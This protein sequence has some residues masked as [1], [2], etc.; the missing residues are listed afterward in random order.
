MVSNP[1]ILLGLDPDKVYDYYIQDSCAVGY[2]GEWQGPCSFSTMFTDI[3]VSLH[4]ISYGLVSWGDYDN[5]NDLDIFILGEN[6][7]IYRND[8]NDLFTFVDLNIPELLYGSAAICDYDNDGDLDFVNSG[9]DEI[10]GIAYSKIYRNDGSDVFTDINADLSGVYLSSVTWG[11]YDNDGDQDLLITGFD[12]DD[13]ETSQFYINE[14]NDK[15]SASDTYIKGSEAGTVIFGDFDNDDYIDLLR[16]GFDNSGNK[17]SIIYRN[18]GDKTF[19][20]INAGLAPFTYSAAVW[21]DFDSD[22]DLDLVITG[23]SGLSQKR[24]IFYRNDGPGDS[25]FTEVN[26]GLHNVGIGGLSSGDFNNDGHLDILLTGYDEFN[27]VTKV[28]L[29]NGSGSFTDSYVTIEGYYNGTTSSGDYDNDGDLDLLISG[30]D[31]PTKIYKNNSLTANT[32]PSIPFNLSYNKKVHGATLSWNSATDSETNSNALSYNL[33]IGT[34]PDTFDIVSPI[35]DTINGYRRIQAMGNAFLDTN[36]VINNIDTGIYYWS[37]QTIDNGF[38]GSEFSDP[39]TFYIQGM[40]TDIKNG[41]DSISSM[42]WGDYDNDNDLDILVAGSGTYYRRYVSKIYANNGND[43]FSEIIFCTDSIDGIVKWG[44][45]DNDGDLDIF[46]SGDKYIDEDGGYDAPLTKIY[47]NDGND[48]FIDINAGLT[49]IHFTSMS[50]G[51]FDNDGDLDIIMSGASG[52][53]PDYNPVSKIYI[54]EGN[55]IFTGIDPGLVSIFLGSIAIGDYNNDSDIDILITGQDSLENRIS[56]IYRN[57]GDL[58]FTDIDAGI[59]GVYR[60]SVAWGDYDKDGDLDIVI[61]GHDVNNNYVT[62][63]YRND[64]GDIFTDINAN[65]LGISGGSANWGDYD[66]DGDLDILV[67]G[68]NRSAVTKIYLNNCD[69]TFT[70]LDIDLESI[71]LYTSYWGDYDNDGDLDFFGPRYFFDGLFRNN[72]NEPNDA[73]YKPPNLRCDFQ[74]SNTVLSWDKASDNQGGENGLSYNIRVGTTPGAYDIIAPM[75]DLNNGY[76]MI[77]EMGNANGNTFF[78]LKD[79]PVGIYYWSV[80]AI[81]QSFAGGEWADEQVITV[82]VLRADFISDTVCLSFPTGFT[83]LSFTSGSPIL[84]WNWDFGDGITSTEQNPTHI[85]ESSG[86]HQV[87]LLVQSAEYSDSIIQEVL[88]KPKPSTDFITDIAC[89]RSST[90]FT[91]NTSLNGTTVTGWYWDFGDGESSTLQDPSSHGYLNSGNYNVKLA[92]YADNGCAD[93]I[94]NIVTVAKYPVAA[95]TASS[96]FEFCSGDSV[97]LSVDYNDNYLYTWKIGAAN[98]TGGDSSKFSA[99]LTGAYSVEVVNSIGNCTTLSGDANIIALDAPSSPYISADGPLSFCDGDSVKL[100]ITENSDYT[101]QW[102]LNGGAVGS[103]S[104]EYIAKNQGAFTVDITNSS[105]C[106]ETSS[107]SIDVVV[108]ESPVTGTVNLSGATEFCEGGSLVMSVEQ[109]DSYTYQWRDEYGII[110]GEITN[111]YTTTE[112]G[113]YILD[114]SNSSSCVVQ[115]TPVNVTV[116][117][118]PITPILQTENYTEGE[119]KGLDPVR[120]YAD[121]Y[122]T[123]N[124]QWVYNGIPMAGET[125]NSLEGSLSEGS[126]SLQVDLNDCNTESDPVSLDFKDAP[127]KPDL[128]VKGPVVWYMAA[129]DNAAAQYKWYHDG[130]LIHDADKFIYVANQ[131]LGTY[132]VAIANDLGCFTISDEI[133]IPTTKSL[134]T[135]FFVPEQFRLDE[136]IDPF[137]NLKIYPN[138]TPGMFTVEMDNH[139]FGE[140]DI[141]IFTNEGRQI[142]NIKFHKTTEHFQSQIDLS[143]QGEGV[144]LIN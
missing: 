24:S 120:I 104:N 70:E 127:A 8:N 142:L 95:I 44:D 18:N 99:K 47:R 9:Q 19:S 40:F 114:I 118:M 45:Y 125:T 4:S 54:N 102:K 57:N 27:K 126:Y 63:V 119:C 110:T 129:S 49:D 113:I 41:I 50:W 55:D 97:V 13:H 67:T 135:D 20:D 74:E 10:S 117:P 7:G 81:D 82:A 62:M 3:N 22:M 138:P 122:T 59:I 140:L 66:S 134:M 112:T 17:H 107:N 11:D 100:S 72:L 5:D 84:S 89:Q 23:L 53:Y 56:K 76:R 39:D 60:S 34:R 103:N 69:D 48:L 91:N 58:S 92:A 38:M 93:S 115:T 15:F 130:T 133:T 65:L 51:D 83:D 36:Y 79:L 132:K 88:V 29:N 108:N 64:G 136:D 123:Y 61:S 85:F 75:S 87:K 46:L 80:Q 98:I 68:R 37:V 137:A 35:S 105:G 12:N 128:Y 121:N 33:R 43:S 77:P 71:G 94:Q 1:Y 30:K 90:S 42:A 21:G 32:K 124:Y 6:T 111:S 16:T 78:I 52:D 131:T 139:I 28:F 26:S 31:L 143:G 144:Y 25:G 116:K 86:T 141:R 96:P 101:Y 2:I 73:P 109:N 106:T 14:G